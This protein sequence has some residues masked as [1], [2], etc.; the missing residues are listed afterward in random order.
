MSKSIVRTGGQS[1]TGTNRPEDTRTPE[2]RQSDIEWLRAEADAWE[3][4]L[5][6]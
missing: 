2:Q 3:K 1:A 4:H 6:R 5:K